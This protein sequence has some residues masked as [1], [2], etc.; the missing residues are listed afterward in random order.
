VLDK[1]RASGRVALVTGASSGIGSAIVSRLLSLGLRVAALARRTEKLELLHELHP[2]ADLFTLGVDVRD[3]AALRSAISQIVEKWGGVD[4]LV[5]NA[6][7]GYGGALSE[8]NTEEWREMLDVNIL[9]LCI[10]TREVLGDLRRRQVAGHIF[11]LSSL[12]G[13]R[14]TPGANLYAATKAAVKSLAESL[15]HELREQGNET[16]VTAISPGFVESEFHQRY[17]G[18]AEQAKELYRGGVALEPDAIAD[19]VEYALL[20]PPTTDVNDV[21]LRSV[22][23]KS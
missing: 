3:E 7:L 12:S 15:R 23:Q 5:N 18:S 1:N 16:R 6:G 2:A 21:L 14:L 19:A 8:G 10:A 20:A 4:V 17:F 11:H 13:H 22:R 9:A